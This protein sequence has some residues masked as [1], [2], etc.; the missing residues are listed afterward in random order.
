MELAA[1]SCHIEFLLLGSHIAPQEIQWSSKSFYKIK[2]L[3]VILLK[4]KTEIS[5]V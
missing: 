5:Y 1:A 4:I 2:A 3:T